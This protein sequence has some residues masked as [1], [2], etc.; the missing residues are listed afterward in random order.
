LGNDPLLEIPATKSLFHV[1]FSKNCFFF[2]GKRS[3]GFSDFSTFSSFLKEV[4]FKFFLSPHGSICAN[5]YGPEASVASGRE[6]HASLGVQVRECR[7]FFEKGET[8]GISYSRAQLGFLSSPE[9]FCGQK[10]RAGLGVGS[11]LKLDQHVFENQPFLIQIPKASLSF[12]SFP[13][14]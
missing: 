4:S 8:N 11:S 10:A 5:D 3:L 13:P 14:K 6:T 2:D 9:D 12:L 7:G 1:N